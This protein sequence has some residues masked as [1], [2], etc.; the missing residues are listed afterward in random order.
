[1]QMPTGAKIINERTLILGA[2]DAWV[3]RITMEVGKDTNNAYQFFMDQYPRQ[4]WNLVTAARG[5][6][7]LIVFTRGDRTATIEIRDGTLAVTPTVVLTVSPKNAGT[8]GQPTAR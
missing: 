3:G 8:P 2:G 4:G 7:S 6:N 5:A 1:M